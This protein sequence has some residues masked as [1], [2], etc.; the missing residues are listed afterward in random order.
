MRNVLPRKKI[1]GKALIVSR[2]IN[3]HII[4]KLND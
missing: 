2:V 4:V 1:L 3:D